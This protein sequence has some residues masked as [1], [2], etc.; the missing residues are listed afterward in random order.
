MLT[1]GLGRIAPPDKNHLLVMARRVVDQTRKQE[2]AYRPV[3]LSAGLGCMCSAQFAQTLGN[4]SLPARA[5]GLPPF[6][7]I[8]REAN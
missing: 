7:D 4:A 3:R 1:A 8:D 2:A 5:C 6:N